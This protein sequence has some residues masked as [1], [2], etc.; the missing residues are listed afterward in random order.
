[1]TDLTQREGLSKD[2]IVLLITV[3]LIVLSSLIAFL[4]MINES[5]S[6]RA[7]LLTRKGEVFKNAGRVSGEES[8][9]KPPAEPTILLP[10]AFKDHLT[11][12][13]HLVPGSGGAAAEA[14]Y[15]PEGEKHTVVM[16]LN[17]YARAT[18]HGD[19]SKANGEIKNTLGARY[20]KDQSSMVINNRTTASTG[21]E[22][23]YSSYFIGW[24]K[25]GWS[26]KVD[27]SYKYVTPKTNPKDNLK[28]VGDN[29]VAYIEEYI[30]RQTG[31][32]KAQGDFNPRP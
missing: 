23:S 19:L 6:I 14:I 27:V 1:M 26:F 31:S 5:E 4:F 24:S 12:A 30:A 15:E 8:V 18:W 17:V 22:E 2:A 32:S 16:P 11:N 13:R 9:T 21:F 25:G 3:T 20:P 7:S 10:P 28:K 29:A